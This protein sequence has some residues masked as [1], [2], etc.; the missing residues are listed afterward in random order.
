MDP[1]SLA[2]ESQCQGWLRYGHLPHKPNKMD[3]RISAPLSVAMPDEDYC[4]SPLESFE[5]YGHLFGDT[6]I[7]TQLAHFQCIS[8]QV[9]HGLTEHSNRQS[10]IAVPV[11]GWNSKHHQLVE[12]S[13]KGELAHSWYIKNQLHRLMHVSIHTLAF[14]RKTFLKIDRCHYRCLQVRHKNMVK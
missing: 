14:L 4:N 7:S 13:W 9:P 8:Y 12:I 3:E 6:G 1:V 11:I 2:E 5:K 10:R